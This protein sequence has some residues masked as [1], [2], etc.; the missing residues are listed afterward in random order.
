MLTNWT[1]DSWRGF[2]IVQVPE[3]PDQH[4]LAGLF[5]PQIDLPAQD[6]VFHLEKE[7]ELAFSA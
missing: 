3:Y 2:P 4:Q 7:I 5:E 1:P 6:E